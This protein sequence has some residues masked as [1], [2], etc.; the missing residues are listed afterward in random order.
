MYIKEI[1]LSILLFAFSLVTNAQ[2]NMGDINGDGTLNIMILGTTESINNNSEEFSPYQI[3]IEL[4][5]ILLA[6]TSITIASNVVAEDIYRSKNVT[7]GIANQNT[8]N[9]DYYCHSLVQY[10]YWPEDRNQRMKYL[11]G[12]TLFNWDYV[13]IGSDPYILSNMPG[14]YSLGVNKIAKIITDGGAVPFLLMPWPKDS[15]SINHFEEFTYRTVDGAKVFIENIPAGL[16]WDSLPNNKKDIAVFHPS[17]NGAYLSAASIYSNIFNRS[18]S[19][20]NY[21][22]DDTIADISNSIIVNAQ[23]SNHYSGNRSFISPFK[24]C[25]INDSILIYN[26]GGT[27]TEIGIQNGLN[28]VVTEAQKILQFSTNPPIHFNYGRSSMGSTHLYVVDSSRFDFSFGYPL[29]DDLSTGLISM[30]YG[31]DQRVNNNDVETD[32]GVAIHMI[33]NSELPYARNVPLRTL[34]SQMIEDIPGVDIF[35]TFPVL[36]PWHLSN[37]V[38]K[39]IAAYIYTMLTGDCA[40][41]ESL[42]PVDSVEWRT[43]MSHRIGYTTAWNVMHIQG[44]NPCYDSVLTISNDST[45]HCYLTTGC[46]WAGSN[47]SFPGQYNSL[48]DCQAACNS[49]TIN[50]IDGNKPK[51]LI[52]VIDILGRESKHLKNQPIFYIYDDGTVEKRITIN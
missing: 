39:A 4:Q 8:S 34:I 37:D 12:D 6:D 11:M 15:I 48:S 52:K 17:P 49:T 35:R 1:S 30:Q 24:S 19:F 43:M 47:P 9:L 18:A 50:N 26:H 2:I 31:I 20:S 5:N 41:E 44:I 16:A 46:Q 25:E 27:S 13:V 3:A 40:L 21:V 45:W 23:S 28:W 36:D 51:T 10:Y 32:L 14:F 7:T 29:Q 22:Y 42:P 38:N 33:N